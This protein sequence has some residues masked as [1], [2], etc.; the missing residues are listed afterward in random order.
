MRIFKRFTFQ[1]AFVLIVLLQHWGFAQHPGMPDGIFGIGTFNNTIND[2]KVQP[3]G[4]VVVV[5]SF[6]NYKTKIANRIARLNQDGTFDETFNIGTGADDEIQTICLGDNGKILIGGNF[7]SFNGVNCNR[8]VQ[9]NSDGS[10]DGNFN[11]GTG[12]SSGIYSIKR[13]IDNKFI[14]AGGFTVFNGQNRKGILRIN[15]DGSIDDS[16]RL[17]NDFLSSPIIWQFDFQNDQIIACGQFMATFNGGYYEY[18][19]RINNDGSFDDSFNP[20]GPN[21]SINCIAVQN[22]GKI[23]VS[24]NFTYISGYNRNRLARLNSDGTLDQTFNVGTGLNDIARSI[25]IT[26]NNKILVAGQYTTYNSGN[27]PYLNLLNQDGSPDNTFGNLRG[28][29]GVIRKIEFQQD[30]KV[31]LGGAFVTYGGYSK[32]KL[33]RLNS[34]GLIDESFL[35]NSESNGAVGALAIQK[36]GK[37]VVFESLNNLMLD[38]RLIRYKPNG[39]LDEGFKIGIIKE[40]INYIKILEDDKIMIAGRIYQYNTTS[41]KHLIKLHSNGSID[42]SFIPDINQH[43]TLYTIAIQQDKKIIVGGNFQLNGM[44]RLNQNGSLDNTFSIGS[45]FNGS[46][47]SIVVQPDKKI[48]AG[49]DF[50]TFNG[51]FKNRI[52]RLNPDGTIDDTFNVGSGAN[53]NVKSIQIKSD[54]KILISGDFTS[55]NGIIKNRIVQLNQ[56]GSVDNY[57][58]SGTGANNGIQDMIITPDQ[59]IYICGSF[60]TYNGTIRNYIARINVDGSIDNSF[61]IGSGA[62]ATILRMALQENGKIIAGAFTFSLFN[63][64][65]YNKLVRLNTDPIGY[66]NIYG[67]VSILPSENC[68]F[69]EA[70]PLSSIIIK[71]NPGPFYG[72]SDNFG[73]YK[74]QVDSGN[75]TY[76]LT[77]QF[78]SINS[79]LL[80]P[81]CSPSHTVALKGSSKDTCCFN[82]AN[83]IKQCALL[84]VNVQ[85]TRMRRC[86]K[87]T[88]Y[89]TYCNYGNAS[90][91]GAQIKVEYPE[92]VVPLSSVPMWSSKQGNVL[93]YNLGDIAANACGKITI[94]DSVICG[95]EAIRGLTQCIKA[96]ISPASNCVAENQSWDKSFVKVTGSCVNGS[97]TFTITNGGSGSMAGNNEYRVFVNDTLVYTGSFKLVSGQSLTVNY[98]AMGQTVRLEADQHP[99]HPGRSRP[100]ATVE[101]CG[102]SS[103]KTKRMVT[104]APLDDLDEETAIT[105]N[106]IIDSYDPNDKLTRPEGIGANRKIVPGQELEYIIR[107]QNTGTDT[108]YT[109]RIVDTLDIALDPGSFIQGGSSHNYKL[110]I[111]GKGK[112]VLTFNHYNINLP[113]SARNQ[114]GSNGF[115]SFRITVPESTPLGTI[116][117]NKAYIYFDYNSPIITNET[118]HT[119]DNTVETDFIRGLLVQEG[120]VTS[121]LNT[122]AKSV[123]LYPN[124]AKSRITVELPET[125]D[126][127]EFR[128]ITIAGRLVKTVQLTSERQEV[129]L[130]GL[131][132]GMYMYEVWESGERKAGG[133][134]IKN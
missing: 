134:I 9:L 16:F 54:G 129:N 100:R 127:T 34:N 77:P 4:K 69:K 82:F 60:T 88:S 14:V 81:Q 58:D 124:P 87:S 7:T 73:S 113:D 116:I 59:K 103:N 92:Y 94:T 66:N 25:V 106:P 11:I 37:V 131:E 12:A 117:S 115:V 97:A 57:F 110:D 56:D 24:G 121:T 86:F 95:N 68:D 105:C 32:N 130:E 114:I 112:A 90:A 33:V 31:L 35:N 8:L 40:S 39:Q 74:V 98:P 46:V 18:I 44:V 111:S 42:D 76:T 96:T 79:K 72:G 30:G 17:T 83:E 15:Q 125:G 61:N 22:D 122:Y 62:N 102:N 71:T 65:A 107:F 5:G 29:D 85:S 2:L 78:N 47:F 84:N 13:T 51:S 26:N 27:R 21:N 6:T 99:L 43:S 128:L 52:I 48:I 38:K 55:F 108:A 93:T 36:D 19:F 63:K 53:N 20:Q 75:V 91:S 28:A 118:M 123:R 80:T 101:D 45:G 3:D 67:K 49:G 41:T 10:I 120:V 23:V 109:V 70:Y 133:K 132:E 64:I 126:P 119:V 89:V 104:T 50:T 1:L